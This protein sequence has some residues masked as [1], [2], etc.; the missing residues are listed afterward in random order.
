M[1]CCLTDEEIWTCGNDNTIRLY[2]L[3]GELLRDIPTYSGNMPTDIAIT[4]R[5]GNRYLVY[6]DC[7]HG[8]VNIMKSAQ[9][10]EMIMLEYWN[11]IAVCS[12]S[13]G[14]FLVIMISDSG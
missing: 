6:I 3:K 12:T 11:P 4:K 2:N 14:E 1:V 8:T 10:Q 7:S 13:S 9:V 5:N